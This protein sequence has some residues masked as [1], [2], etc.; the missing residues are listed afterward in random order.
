MTSA[1]IEILMVLVP[2][3]FVGLVTMLAVLF[4]EWLRGP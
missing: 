2:T 1:A 4:R 3:T